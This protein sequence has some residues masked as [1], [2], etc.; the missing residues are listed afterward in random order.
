MINIV[1]PVYPI[2]PVFKKNQDLDLVKTKKYITYLLKRGAKNLMITAGT[3]RINLL[4][5]VE[6]SKL[7]KLVAKECLKSKR[8]SITS[9]HIYGDLKK[10]KKFINE[11][12]KFK[13]KAII[14]Y[15][16]ER[17][18]ND[19]QLINFF[20]EINKICKNKIVFLIHAFQLRNE[21]PN[22]EKSI[23]IP[24]NVFESLIKMKSFGGIKEEFNDSRLRLKLIKKYKKKMNIITAGSSMRSY[25][26]LC[27][28]GLKSYLTSVGSFNP[29]IEEDFFN[30]LFIKKNQKKAE[31]LAFKYEPFFEDNKYL[32]WHLTMRTVLSILKIMPKYERKPL[33]HASNK[34][35][36]KFEK[37]SKKLKSYK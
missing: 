29:K 10:T 34:V 3:S 17:Y 33:V 13:A 25:L 16:S 12:I 15:F 37:K 2:C 27:K 9:N 7:N 32:G 31:E 5:D 6:L 23:S 28:F 20:K 4:S 26:K 24:I 8:I 11:S 35:F 36:K 18:Y 21:D 30:Y 22:K 14:I 1:G 19:R